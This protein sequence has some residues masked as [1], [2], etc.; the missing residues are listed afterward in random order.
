M[1]R[2]TRYL[3]IIFLC[4]IIS[5]TARTTGFIK[6]EGQLMPSTSTHSSNVLFY[7]QSPS[8]NIYLTKDGLEYHVLK[9][10]D[11]GRKAEENEGKDKKV[12]IERIVLQ[13]KGGLILNKNI[14]TDRPLHIQ[15]NFY[16][17]NSHYTL[18]SYE[19][20]LV[21]DV[22]PGIDWLF[23][24]TPESFKYEFIV[25]PGAD[26]RSIELLLSSNKKAYLSEEGDLMIPNQNGELKEPAP[27]SYL[28]GTRQK[29]P[30]SF[31]LKSQKR[32][33]RG[34]ETV[35]GFKCEPTT[36][37]DTLVIDPILTWSTFFGSQ[38][39]EGT[40]AIEKDSIGNT[41]AV[42]YAGF[43]GFPTFSNGG[44]FQTAFVSN[45]GFI[46][47]F[48]SLG[49][50]QWCTYFGGGTQGSTNI[51]DIKVTKQGRIYI[52]GATTSPIFPVLGTGFNQSN[53]GGQND[54]FVACF[55]Q[56]S[57]LIW[58]TF[59]GGTGT[60]IGMNLEGDQFGNIFITGTTN[61]NNFPLMNAGT[62]FD[63]VVGIPSSFISKFSINH[64]LIWSTYLKYISQ[65]D[66]AID[67]QNRVWLCASSASLI[68]LVNLGSGA[69]FQN[70]IQGS[71]EMAL[72]RFSNN[73]NV[74]WST[75]FGGSGSD[76]PY[77]ICV[78][79]AD[80]IYVSGTTTSTNFPTLQTGGYF[81][82]S[83]GAS[84][85][86]DAFIVQFNSQAQLVWSTYLGG[87][88]AETFA[89]TDNLAVDTCDN[90]YLAFSSLSTDMPIQNACDGGY[91]KSKKDTASPQFADI[92]LA[93][94]H[95]NHQLNWSTYIGGDGSDFRSPLAVDIRGNLVLS[96]EWASINSSTTYP[97]AQTT[98]NTYTSNFMG[99]DDIFFMS[100]SPSMNLSSFSYSVQCKDTLFPI[101]QGILPN[102]GY[103]SSPNL[104]I[105]SISGK[106]F[107]QLS[108]KGTHTITFHSDNSCHC[109]LKTIQTQITLTKDSLMTVT[110]ALVC[111][112][113]RFQIVASGASTYLWNGGNTSP[114]LT[115]LAGQPGSYT[116]AV[117]GQ[118]STG[119][120]ALKTVSIE[121][122]P[123]LDASE[124][125]LQEV[126]IHPNPAQNYIEITG[127][128]NTWLDV[129]SLEG[130]L[131]QSFS[132]TNNPQ[133][134]YIHYKPGVYLIRNRQQPK[135]TSLKLIV[136]P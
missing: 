45:E 101:I 135:Q 115:T 99:T 33:F 37:K 118:F 133:K 83:L 107:T 65:P 125:N 104:K 76:T 18:E 116:F 61:S 29:V 44:Y 102:G 97:I 19:R 5:V 3:V 134:V 49:V 38:G 78:N 86:L 54:A 87:S 123:C 64:T 27:I 8:F 56:T 26:Y 103:F 100:F 55:D 79:R 69:Y 75:Y 108:P 111:E 96:G 35:L 63:N 94:F 62:Y 12:S 122:V 92:Y 71:M 23:I 114:T 74:E 39:F 50:L 82:N 136:V 98:P 40:Q 48:N 4:L 121:V 126:Q 73:G 51:Y 67:K 52:C 31:L 58:S 120:T 17:W 109:G 117:N 110:P 28:Q 41:Y 20:I 15:Q 119:C 16:R 47:K 89:S 90:V 132:I 46:V 42:G 1:Q 88:L 84:N 85:S 13:L 59:L 93:S 34:W 14:K 70:S 43:F 36:T 53:I 113:D 77:S 30:S 22:Y 10:Q 25:Y 7:A 57:N 112:G 60:D 131:I 72:M 24:I 91:L 80:G 105:D 21:K 128:I 127:L 106:I 81:D 2:K 6:N 68:P 32:H 130:A 11:E 9:Y 129:Y 66:L 95:K 124:I